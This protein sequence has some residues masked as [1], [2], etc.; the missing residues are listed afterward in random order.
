MYQQGQK[1]GAESCSTKLL[2]MILITVCLP[3]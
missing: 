1:V 3:S 2:T